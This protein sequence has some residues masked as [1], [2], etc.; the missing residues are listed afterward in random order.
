M[1]TF[2]LSENSSTLQLSDLKYLAELLADWLRKNQINMT[3]SRL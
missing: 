1:C 3:A 2:A